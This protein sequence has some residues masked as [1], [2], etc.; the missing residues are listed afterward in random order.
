[1]M[2]ICIIMTKII[3]IMIIAQIAAISNRCSFIHFIILLV[4]RVPHTALF[5]IES[6]N[7]NPMRF[8]GK[9]EPKFEISITFHE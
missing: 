5:A 2:A 1:M 4:I 7:S 6:V 8:K 9:Y 3:V